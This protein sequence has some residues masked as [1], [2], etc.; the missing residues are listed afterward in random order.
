MG[1]QERREK[2]PYDVRVDL[3]GRE[4]EMADVIRRVRDGR[5]VT[6]TGP[7]GIG[8]TRLA[9]EVAVVVGPDFE[10][11]SVEVD[12]TRID[13]EDGV[14]EAVAGQLG[15]ADFGALVNSTGDQPTL[16]VLDNCEHVLDAAADVTRHLLDACEMPTIIATSRSPLDLPEESVITLGPLATP[17]PD[18][19]DGA[20]DAV[21]SAE[22]FGT[23]I[24]MTGIVLSKLDGDA[25]G[26]AALSAAAVT[27][28]P[29]RFAGVGEKPGDLEPFQP[30]RMVGRVLGAGDVLGLIEKAEQA[31]DHEQ[32]ARSLERLRRNE[33]TL[34]DYRDQLRQL[35]KLGSLQQ[36]LEMLPGMGGKLEG[37]DTERGE[38]ELK[39][40]GVI[41]DSM[42]L[43]ERRDPGVINGS[44]RRRIADGSGTRVEDVNRL[45]KQFQQARKMMKGMGGAKGR[46]LK[47]LAASMPSQVR[48]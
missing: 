38:R 36:V 5:L 23:R 40:A 3:V 24:G 46:K 20:S 48:F 19:A 18:V 13:R 42:T 45:L 31:I 26:G 41:I 14:A 34:E 16:V 29:V 15:Y 4:T 11:G 9:R 30:E 25:R 28:C 32:A 1:S 12:L 7:G 21:R 37:V 22:E 8:K 43:R 35:G 10:Y 6:I 2:V 44:R 27:G 47:Q 33:F 17:P 39:L